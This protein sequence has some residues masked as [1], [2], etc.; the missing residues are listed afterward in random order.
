MARV[1]DHQAHAFPD[2]PANTL[3]DGV[4]HLAV[5]RV[6]PPGEDVRRSQDFVS[7]AVLGFIQRGC[8]DFQVSVRC[9]GPAIAPWMPWG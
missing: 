4:V 1:Q 9:Q 8:S 3:D 7:E 6:T 2:A 5:G